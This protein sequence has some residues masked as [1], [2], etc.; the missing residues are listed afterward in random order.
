MPNMG[1]ISWKGSIVRKG[2]VIIAKNYLSADEVDMLNRLV[3]IF[4]ETAQLRAKNRVNLT[5]DFWCEN[6][7]RML[8]GND[9]ALLE[10][11]D[12]VS[13][14][15][16]EVRAGAEYDTFNDRRKKQEAELADAQDLEELR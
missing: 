5:M 10:H 1:L 11:K 13:H 7:D 4:L 6:A 12:S 3:V 14:A 15:L 8:F 2:D 9:M 16:M